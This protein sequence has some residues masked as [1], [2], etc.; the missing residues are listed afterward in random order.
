MEKKLPVACCVMPHDEDQD[1][2]II[3]HD[4]VVSTLPVVVSGTLSKNQKYQKCYP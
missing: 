2:S 3:H 4:V 1:G